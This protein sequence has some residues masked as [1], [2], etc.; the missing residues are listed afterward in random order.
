MTI[1]QK[2]KSKDKGRQT[3]GGKKCSDE[4]ELKKRKLRVKKME[5]RLGDSLLR[6]LSEGKRKMSRH[7]YHIGDV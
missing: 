3:H 4:D 7:N 2:M 1:T 6:G 5:K